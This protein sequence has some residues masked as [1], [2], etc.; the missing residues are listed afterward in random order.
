MSSFMINRRQLMV[1]GG[2]AASMMSLGVGVQAAPARRKVDIV[3]T[4]G[5]TGMVIHELTKSQGYFD[6]FNIDPNV[7]LVSDGT[8]CVAALVSGASKICMWSGFN[9]VPPAI[10]RGATLKILAGALTLPSLCMYAKRKDIKRVKDLEGKTIG[11]GA[12]GAVL[13]QMTVFLLTKKGVDPKKVTFRN[14]GSNADVFKAV[15]S[16]SID[17]GLSDVDVFDR[18]G[19][20][21]VH[22]LP[23]GMLWQEIPEYTNQASYASDV[24]IRDNRDDLVRVL[25]AY[26][27]GYRYVCGPDS[28]EAFI[29]AREKITGKSHLLE[30]TTQWNWI[31]K[32]QPYA[33][34]LV[35]SEAQVNLVQKLNVNL[36]V[37]KNILPFEKVADMSLARDALKLVG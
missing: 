22:N 20:Y 1:A 14:V 32:Y 17:A 6:A 24:A 2:C 19:E 28:K 15:V 9:Q 23:D 5:V 34:K 12:V 25:A 27:K 26:D 21:G 31:R 4:H 18:Q 37:Q 8:K 33:L 11:I 13:H 35:L 16:G 3:M 29:K 10:A 30:A 36:D 7:L